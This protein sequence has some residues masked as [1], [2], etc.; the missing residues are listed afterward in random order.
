M[1]RTMTTLAALALVLTACGGGSEPEPEPAPDTETETGGGETTEG[2]TD[3]VP[4]RADATTMT[5][6]EC[7]DLH[8]G[9]VVGDPGD[10]STHAPEYL[11][12]N[13]APPLGAVAQGI[14]GSVCCPE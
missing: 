4:T 13:G 11:C 7:T 12:P 8:H 10:G 3:P 2:P 1:T 5:P 9:R 14:E 6:E